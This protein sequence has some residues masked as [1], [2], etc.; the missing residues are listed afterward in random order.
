MENLSLKTA[1]NK[2]IGS[3]WI[4]AGITF[5]ITGLLKKEPLDSGDWIRDLAFC[6]IGILFFTPVVGYDN[7][8]V[9]ICDSCLKIR[10]IFWYR[11]VTV[12]ESE[13]D[14]IL[15]ARNG[16][17]IRRKDQ[18]PVKI[19]LYSLDKKQKEQVYRF[20]TDYAHEKGFNRETRPGQI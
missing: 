13:I 20:F 18:K 2:I 3:I 15:L 9:E 19:N 7:A 11:W 1:N 8:I 5:L 14:S 6:I 12:S 16:V 10:W 4:L 17:L